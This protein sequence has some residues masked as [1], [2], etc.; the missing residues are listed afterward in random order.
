M[1]PT[2]ITLKCTQSGGQQVGQLQTRYYDLTSVDEQKSLTYGENAVEIAENGDT[3]YTLDWSD[4]CGALPSGTYQISIEFRD[5]YD[6][7]QIHPLI[8][9]FHNSQ[10]YGLDFEI[11]QR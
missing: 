10:Y 6:E 5:V 2:G 3:L 4:A 1:T 11:P 9:K 8:R 7:S